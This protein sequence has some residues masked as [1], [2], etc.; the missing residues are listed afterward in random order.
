M[1]RII[2]ISIIFSFSIGKVY[3]GEF[4]ENPSVIFHVAGWEKNTKYQGYSWM[5]EAKAFAYREDYFGFENTINL[6]DSYNQFFRRQGL[7][8][9][10][11]VLHYEIDVSK[12]YMYLLD[13]YSNT[14]YNEDNVA[15]GINTKIFNLEYCRQ[16]RF[17]QVNPMSLGAFI[18]YEKNNIRSYLSSGISWHHEKMFNV[19]DF[20]ESETTV[21]DFY[22]RYY[23]ELLLLYKLN[24]FRFQYKARFEINI[25]NTSTINFDNELRITYL[26][27]D[28][29][30][31]EALVNY[32]YLDFSYN[33]GKP[34]ALIGTF[35]LRVEV[36][37]YFYDKYYTN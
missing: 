31:L 30:M 2:L 27:T 21:F 19:P 12:A 26:I 4:I 14:F 28:W 24:D 18:S 1:Y 36:P 7:T 13:I 6:F 29:A 8:R 5:I 16:F 17:L 33:L 34:N 22:P 10:E 20:L 15:I 11:N 25:N 37:S 9:I 35:G 23:S 32:Q 3:S